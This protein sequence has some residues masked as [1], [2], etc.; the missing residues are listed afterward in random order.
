MNQLYA[1]LCDYVTR[2]YVTMSRKKFK[3]YE[4]STPNE[5]SMNCLTIGKA[6]PARPADGV[7]VGARL[8]KYIYRLPI[9]DRGRRPAE[10][11][12]DIIT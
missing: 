5:L 3:C 12:C 11:I 9:S 2:V 6:S 1:V 8:S 10:A 7:K 4:S